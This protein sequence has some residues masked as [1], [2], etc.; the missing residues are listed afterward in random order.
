MYV[1]MH[2]YSERPKAGKLYIHNNL[3]A[4]RKMYEEMYAVFMQKKYAEITQLPVY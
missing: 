1:C 4:A 2:K 3:V